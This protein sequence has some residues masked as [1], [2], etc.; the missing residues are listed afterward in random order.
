MEGI[1]MCDLRFGMRAST[2]TKVE[3]RPVGALGGEG[4]GFD[5]KTP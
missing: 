4:D 2:R 5:I 1:W 3:E